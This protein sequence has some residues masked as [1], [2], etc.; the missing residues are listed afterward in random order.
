M[1]QCAIC[2]VVIS[3]ILRAVTDNMKTF[4]CAIRKPDVVVSSLLK[5]TEDRV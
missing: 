3:M 2:I 5:Y 4:M 1:G